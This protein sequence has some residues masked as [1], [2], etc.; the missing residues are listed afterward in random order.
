[1]G[2]NSVAQARRAVELTAPH[3]CRQQSRTNVAA[4]QNAQEWQST[5][6]TRTPDEPLQFLRACAQCFELGCSCL[7]R[8]I[9]R[10]PH[11]H[12]RR[13]LQRHNVSKLR[14]MPHRFNS[15]RCHGRAGPWPPHV[16]QPWRR[17]IQ[18]NPRLQTVILAIEHCSQQ[19]Q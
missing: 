7:L 5:F 2:G 12:V 15:H 16:V 4:T 1:M 18:V 17:H 6:V 3:A 11:L 14:T 19:R 8:F 9:Q 13:L 10:L